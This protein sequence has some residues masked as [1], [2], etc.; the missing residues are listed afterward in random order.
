MKRLIAAFLLL[1]QTA[2]GFGNLAIEIKSPQLGMYLQTD[3]VSY[4]T[5]DITEGAFRDYVE[6]V[7][8][9]MFMPGHR[10]IVINSNGGSVAAGEKIIN[11][12]R[13]EQ[14]MGIQMVCVVQ[15]KAHSMA[16][17]ILS[18]CDVKL[19]TK[20][21]RMVVHKARVQIFLTTMTGRM[22]QELANE[23]K[24][25]DEPYRQKNAKEMGLSLKDYDR[26]AD[27][28][29]NWSSETLYQRHY[30]DGFVEE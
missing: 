8:E 10:V 3:K 7:R 15:D 20:H 6:S 4:L 14:A 22:A 28:E 17:N 24:R 18:N 1:T 29:T 13:L 21:A 19:A 16:F 27:A 23:L 5:S 25:V 11:M 2:F 26:Y 12:M 30:L 9:T